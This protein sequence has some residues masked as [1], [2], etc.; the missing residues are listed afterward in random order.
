ML[1][2]RLFTLGNLLSMCKCYLG[3]IRSV[4]DTL[5]SGSRVRRVRYLSFIIFCPFVG[6]AWSYGG[7]EWMR[8]GTYAA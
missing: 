5:P 1:N 2:K 7:K 6:V 3:S 4:K 8:W